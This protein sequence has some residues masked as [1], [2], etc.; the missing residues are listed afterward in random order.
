VRVAA[1]DV[2][3]DGVADIIA[4]SGGRSGSSV[5]VSTVTKAEIT[6]KS[7]AASALPECRVV[8][9]GTPGS[10]LEYYFPMKPISHQTHIPA[11][12]AVRACCP[13]TARGEPVRQK[14]APGAADPGHP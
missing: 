5:R 12:L 1:A 10:R 2:N 8:R 13:Q 9:G 14:E 4:G 3:L 7:F 11:A 6:A